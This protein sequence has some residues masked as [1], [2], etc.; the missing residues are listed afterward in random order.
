[1][2]RIFSFLLTLC[3]PVVVL[4]DSE[5]PEQVA[6]SVVKIQALRADG[7]RSIGSAV[8]IAP[9]KVITNCHVLRYAR[10]IRVEQA[11]RVFAGR[12]GARDEGLDLCVVLVAG[13]DAPTTRYTS[14]WDV[15]LGDEVFAVGYPSGGPLSVSAGKV[16]RLHP[17]ESGQVVQT[18]ACF[19]PGASGGGLYDAE[20][21][22]IGILAF[23][24]ASGGDFHFVLPSE[25]VLKLV[26]EQASADAAPSAKAFW[27]QDA[28][29]QPFFLQAAALEQERD[30]RGLLNLARKW[31]DIESSRTEPWL[32]MGRACSRLKRQQDAAMAFRK[33][34]E[35]NPEHAE[36]TQEL[37]T[38]V[39]NFSDSPV[40]RRYA[41]CDGLDVRRDIATAR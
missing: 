16:R 19:N 28:R 2:P 6:A 32:A 13:L 14:T 40:C 37:Q 41:W 9:E 10:E 11:E 18:S 26:D 5:L 23:K 27:E 39:R 7:S 22:L 1:M 4:C 33:A 20:G 17:Y 30:W 34:V 38:A 24:A 36:A 21:R 29:R 8:V 15:H 25:W 31:S 35:L 3:F 12:M